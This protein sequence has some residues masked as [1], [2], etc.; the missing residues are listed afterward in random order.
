[1][2]R[3]VGLVDEAESLIGPHAWERCEVRAAKSLSGCSAFQFRSALP[4]ISKGVLLVL[5]ISAAL[6]A[7]GL[8]ARKGGSGRGLLPPV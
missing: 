3:Q 7:L 8:S 4:R 6:R 1:V 5:A 2:V